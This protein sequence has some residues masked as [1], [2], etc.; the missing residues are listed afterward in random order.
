MTHL[1]VTPFSG[2]S[3]LLYLSC[4]S[5]KQVS[6]HASVFKSLIVDVPPVGVPDD[7]GAG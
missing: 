2:F 3:F 5:F 1:R 6:L 7:I 4:S